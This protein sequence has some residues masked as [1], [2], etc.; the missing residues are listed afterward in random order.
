M[1][2]ALTLSEDDAAAGRRG[3]SPRVPPWF[4]RGVMFILLAV[5]ALQVAEWLFYNLRSFLGLLFLAW[6]F[7]ITVEPLVDVGVRR[8][9]RRGLATAIV[10]FGLAA[11]SVAFLVVFGAL[12]VDQLSELRDRPPR[13][14]GRRRGLDEPHPGHDLPA[15]GHQRLAAADPRADPA[16]GPGADAGRGRHPVVAGR[17]ALP[18]AHPDPVRLLHDRSGPP[19]ARDRVAVVPAATAAG[20]LDRV[21]DRRRE[22]GRLRGVTAAAG[23][24]EQPPDRGLPLVPRCPLLAAAGDLDRARLAVH[25]DGGHVPGDRGAGADRVGAAAPGRAVG[26]RLRRRLPAGG[27][28]LLRT[29]DHLAD[30]GDPSR[31]RLR[32]RGRRRRALRAAGRAGVGAGRRGDRGPGPDLRPPLRVRRPGRRRPERQRREH[33][34]RN[35][36]AQASTAGAPPVESAGDPEGQAGPTV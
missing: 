35:D 8:G 27:E 19:A 18:G 14:G 12:L 22:D 10:M 5:A 36:A 1:A 13:R 3:R 11:G 9:M 25:P 21:G 20:H 2:G 30:G 17:A 24:A 4:R 26:G 34:D 16:A 32:R 15:P 23:A 33:V 28:L 29:A 31:R 6:L 7:S